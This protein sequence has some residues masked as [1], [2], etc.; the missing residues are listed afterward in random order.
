MSPT[1]DRHLQPLALASPPLLHGGRRAI[2]Q[3]PFDS[4]LLVKVVRWD[5]YNRRRRLLSAFDRFGAYRSM[6]FETKEY[7]AIARR[8]G[9]WPNYLQ[10]YHGIVETNL[11]LGMVVEKLCG[12]DGL[13]APTIHDVVRDQGVTRRLHALC[14]TFYG[15]VERDA[16]VIGDMS[17]FNIVLVEREDGERLVLVDGLGEKSFIPIRSALPLLNRLRIRHQI[18]QSWERL[19]AVAP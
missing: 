8:L 12:P 10:R 3:H 2:Y 13:L 19:K 18:R 7:I 4:G 11:G 14:A 6:L 5:K 15:A 17:L 9:S 1:D 16:C